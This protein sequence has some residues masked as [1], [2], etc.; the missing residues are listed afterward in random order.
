MGPLEILFIWEQ[1]L[2]I[3][4]VHHCTYSLHY[5]A[6]YLQPSDFPSPAS[7]STEAEMNDAVNAILNNTEFMKKQQASN[8][9]SNQ[10]TA[11]NQ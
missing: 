7:P 4:Y 9:A 10:T 3:L 2:T 8:F 6:D 5:Y 1:I 11:T